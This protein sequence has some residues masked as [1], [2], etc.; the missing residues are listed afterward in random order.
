MFNTQ[1]IWFT[2][3]LTAV[4]VVLPSSVVL[5]Q[6]DYASLRKNINYRARILKHDLN[7]TKDTL[8]LSCPQ[9]MYK[10][11]SVGSSKQR[12][13]ETIDGFEYR[14]PLK[15]YKK[16]KYLMVTQLNGLKIVFELNILQREPFSQNLAS[17]L[18]H[19]KLKNKDIMFDKKLVD[20]VLKEKVFAYKPY[21]ISDVDRRGMQSREECRRIQALQRAKLRAEIKK[22]RLLAMQSP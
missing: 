11:Y 3:L 19:D 14:L 1:K 20:V 9:R 12:I 22:R 5:S 8:I 16:G 13:S 15:Q 7:K 21:N 17:S 18:V 10:L 2:W 6:D 4:F